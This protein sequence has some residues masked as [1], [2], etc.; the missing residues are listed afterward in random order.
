[1]GREKRIVYPGLIYHVIKRGNN[2]EAVF[3]ENEDYSHYLNCIQRYKKKYEFKL[4]AF[5]LM[6]NHVHMLIKVTDCGTISKIMQSLTVAHIRYYNEKYNRVG[7]VWQGRFKS[8]IV[9]DDKYFLKAMTYIEQNPLRANL[10]N[11]VRNYPWSS[12]K[13]NC[14]A[15]RSSFVDREE[16]EIFLQLGANDRDRINQY[17]QILDDNLKDSDVEAI[18]K[19]TKYGTPYVSETFVNHI[20]KML[21][22][23]RKRGR[24]KNKT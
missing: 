12:Y 18:R 9:S 5:C 13:L 8:P 17:K 4:F 24:P 23:K 10:V 19:S 2:R 1:M 7:H 3:L 21:P 6:P 14:S 20:A 16:N 11:Q 22:L 15:E